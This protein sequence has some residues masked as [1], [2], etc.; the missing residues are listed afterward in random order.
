MAEIFGSVTP[1]SR[2]SRRLRRI[3]RVG[4]RLN[5]RELMEEQRRC[6]CSPNPAERL[7]AALLIPHALIKRLR[8]LRNFDIGQLLED[9]VLPNLSL[10]APELTICM[11]AADRLRRPNRER[12]L[13]LRRRS[14]K[15]LQQEGEHLLHAE[16]A[17]F[18][19]G[20]PHLLLPFQ[21]NKFASNV[22]MVP[23][24]AQA[25]DCL[26]HAGFRQTRRSS[27]WLVDGETGRP[28]RLVE[29]RT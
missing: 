9:E 20:M 14:R 1:I 7:A 24:V 28:I 2:R 17:L 25:R 13:V 11:E 23:C 18:R 10:L 26:C 19:A 29:N 22:F 3:L 12:V 15:V 21:R 8:Q 4:K 5:I 27:S 6:M 16:A